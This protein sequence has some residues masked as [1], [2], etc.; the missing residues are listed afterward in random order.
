[1]L[2]DKTLTIEAVHEL[3]RRC[4]VA[5]G[6]DEDNAQAVA[7]TVTAAERDGCLSHGLF[8]VPGY[9]AS[10][11]SGKVNGRANPSV[12]QIAPAVIQVDGDCG[13][14]PIALLRGR[15]ALIERAKVTGLA[16]LAIIKTFH[17][18]ALW[19]EV[20]S[21]CEQGLVAFA[22][23]SGMPAVAPA[24]STKALFGTDPMAFGWPRAEGPPMVFDQASA[25]WAMGEIMLAARAGEAVPLG[26]GLDGNGQPTTD[27]QAILEGGAQLPFGGYKGSSIAMMVELLVG[28]LL[29][30]VFSFEA[31]EIHSEHAGPSRGGEL[32]IAIDPNHFG[33]ASNWLLHSERFFQRI[34]SLDGTRLPGDR[35]L[36]NRI[37]HDK[38]GVEVLGALHEELLEL[39]ETGSG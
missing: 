33:D 20:E 38:S 3:T 26:V 2:T 17:F 37:K 28:S 22:F 5:N 11:R 39:T 23:N 25:A 9:V 32:L 1:M 31:G 7:W 10:L 27:P 4:L 13:Y 24:G 29:G 15:D 16:A 12:K 8:R 19:P 30:D 14:T 21:I 35:R 36:A 6:C 34:L 18:A